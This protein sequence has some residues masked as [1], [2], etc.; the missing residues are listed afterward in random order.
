[1]S[2]ASPLNLLALHG[3]RLKGFAEAAVVARLVDRPESDI[4][5]QLEEAAGNGFAVHRD[6]RLTGWTLTPAGRGENERLLAE[7]LDRL[8]ARDD[9]RSAYRRFLGSNGEML[10]VCTRWQVREV[11]GAQALNDHSDGAY[12]TAVIDELAA[13][14]EAVQPICGELADRLDRFGH[15]APRFSAALQKV[16]AGEHE[17]F[18]KPIIESYH[19]VWFELHEDLLATLGIDRASEASHS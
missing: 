4:V 18:T 8:G 17:W 1:M 14:D 5:S 15:Y 16:R 11:D 3:L 12:D 19:T 10:A 13:L 9:V 6:G 2:H 7:E